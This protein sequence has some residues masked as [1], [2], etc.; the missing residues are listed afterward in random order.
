[1]SPMPESTTQAYESLPVGTP[2]DMPEQSL[3]PS[4]RQVQ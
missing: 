3:R 2:I 1:M 4:W